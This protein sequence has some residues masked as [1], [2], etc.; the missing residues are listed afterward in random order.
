MIDDADAKTLTVPGNVA[1]TAT[2]AIDLGWNIALTFADGPPI[3][4][5][6]R[7]ARGTIRAYGVW[8]LDDDRAKW[9]GGAVNRIPGGHLRTYTAFKN[10]L[11]E[12]GRVLED[13][14]F[15]DVA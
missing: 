9:S 11:A 6:L 1:N 8:H 15:E 10:L 13:R 12:Y 4:V 14:L 3:N 5:A 2:L 7:V